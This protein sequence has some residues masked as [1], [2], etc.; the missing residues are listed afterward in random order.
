M[1][2]QLFDNVGAIGILSDT[3]SR[4]LPDGAWSD[5]RNV[6]FDGYV[7]R[8]VNGARAVQGSLSAA[9]YSIFAHTT[10]DGAQFFAYPGLTSVFTVNSNT[11]YDITRTLASG[12]A[13]AYNTDNTQLW[14]GGVLGGLLFLN[15]GVDVPQIQLTPTASCRLSDLPN[16]P[17]TI[18]TRCAVMRPY[19]NYL[20]ALD[21]TKGTIRY[22]QMV[23]W[24]ASADPLTA[25]HTWDEA[26]TT[27]DAGETSL[28]E[29]NGTVID[30]LPMRDI[31][32]IYKDDSVHGMQFTGGQF[33]FRFY[34]IFNGVGILAKRCVAAFEQYHC[35]VGN[36]LDVY[37]H[38]GNSIRSIAQDK[39]RTW[40]R[41][42]IDGANYERTF[43]VTNPVTSE[44]WICIP[45][46]EDDYTSKVLMWNWRK[47]TWGV[48]DLANVSAGA[49]GGIESSDYIT[50]WDSLTDTWDSWG[51]TW[52]ELDSLPPDKKL[53]LVSPTRT[54]GLIETEFGSS[55]FGAALPFALERQNIWALPAKI[56][57]GA[58]VIDLQ[59]VKFIRRVR[60]RTVEQS[61]SNNIT[62]MVAVQTDVD[63][64]LVWQSTAKMTGNTAEI[65]VFKRGRFLSVRLE[66][67]ADTVLSLLSFEV[68]FDPSG[69]YL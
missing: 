13:V 68:D 52:S 48:R 43:V 47:D 3:N 41:Q 30:C 17:T 55:E 61:S 35:F 12:T 11:H 42:N 40:L 64:T 6:R 53:V 65:T 19:R 21:V 66:S 29:T 45:N 38:D 16:W 14:T 32:I 23:K 2:L 9:P 1:P 34:Q 18:T 60:F 44:V 36:D 59:G 33:I 8:K 20:V 54:T 5:G 46:G 22:R 7:A 15:N 25:P 49:T 69:D 57:D 67:D 56:K 27:A 26:D 24:S 62:Y 10:F 50:P 28:S 51:V 63:S 4:K 58:R 37:V 31:N 39:W